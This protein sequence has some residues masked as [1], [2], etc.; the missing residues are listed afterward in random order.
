MGIG[1]PSLRVPPLI[2]TNLATQVDEDLWAL[3][4]EERKGRET[5][6]VERGRKQ[7]LRGHWRGRVF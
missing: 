4:T 2:Q 5:Q 3:K 1:I 6:E 7:T